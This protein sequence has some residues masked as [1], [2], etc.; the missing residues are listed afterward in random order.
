MSGGQA[1]NDSAIGSRIADI[2]EER[3]FRHLAQMP[4]PVAVFR[5]AELR[6]VFQNADA[7]AVLG[8]GSWLGKVPSEFSGDVEDLSA[9]AQLD[10][11]YASGE[12][13]VIRDMPFKV[14]G[15][16]P[17]AAQAFFDVTV[18][19]FRGLDD[20]IE[21]VMVVCSDVTERHRRERL[22]Q[23]AID[24]QAMLETMVRAMP[25]GVVI[26]DR[27][28]RI[29]HMNEANAKLNRC[30]PED[31]IGRSAAE[32]WPH[33][34]ADREAVLRRVLD[35]GEAIIDEEVVHGDPKSG[36]FFA[37]LISFYPIL[38]PD[39]RVVGVGVITLD[40]TERKRA[41]RERAELLVR[42][43]RARAEAEAERARMESLL[44]QAPFAAVL[45]EGPDHV[46]RL[47]NPSFRPFI[48][49]DNFLGRPWREV[50][51]EAVENGIMPMLDRVYRTGEPVFMNEF[52]FSHTVNGVRKQN[53]YTFALQP[54]RDADGIVRGVM[55][56]GL[57]VTEQVAARKAVEAANHEIRRREEF[58]RSVLDQLPQVV[59]TIDASQRVSFINGRWV[60]WTGIAGEVQGEGWARVLHPD[61][62]PTVRA[63]WME[64]MKTLA[65]WTVECRLRVHDGTFRWVQAR[66]LPMRDQSSGQVMWLGV[67]SDIDAQKRMD[68]QRAELF[69]R[70]RAAREEAENASRLKDQFLAIVS[71]ELRAPLAA[72]LLWEGLLRSPKSDE[73]LK[74]KA[75]DA[76][77]QSA[78]A[79]AKLIED[80]LD[81]SRAIS[82]KL[83][84]DQQPV[85][86]VPVIED[87]IASEL[88]A[89]NLKEIRIESNFDRSQGQVL[90]DA[91]RLKQIV[92]NLLSNA[93]KFT[94]AGGKVSV[95]AEA[96]EDFIEITVTDT[97]RGIAP[98][99]Q[100]QLF[101]P[102]SQADGSIT[103]A[104]GGLGL[105][106]SIV[107]RLVHLHGGT[108]SAA[109]RG[110][111]TGATFTVQ[112]PR[113][114][115]IT[116]V[117]RS[118]M[119]SPLEGTLPGVRILLVDDET[120]VREALA[121]ILQIA[122]AI[123]TRA[124]SAAEGLRLFEQHAFDLV[125]GDLSMPG[126]D[127][128]SFIRR[129]RS[130][131]GGIG[132][133]VVAV[134]LTAH[135]REEER[136][137]AIE[138]GYHHHLPK[139]IEPDVLVNTLVALLK[140]HGART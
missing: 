125:I 3:L 84:I 13:V 36:L 136:T 116:D 99:F 85:D 114:R 72:L 77:R 9:L 40:I 35:S 55:S 59:W 10:R 4:F 127:G 14:K 58:F 107:H 44:N 71:H 21:G 83:H 18:Q 118:P 92:V 128:F 39:D 38:T 73:A 115:P 2:S 64:S 78:R 140:D 31:V 50:K 34:F 95:K 138:A 124:S 101:K 52:P 74:T 111:G 94:P 90:G 67:A 108:V 70:E 28:L 117:V 120:D 123:P 131:P 29:T 81:V 88:Q 132:S 66:S 80:L 41:E 43:Q 6:C 129:L 103:R 61:D 57:N 87:A 54:V 122:G 109:S 104:H 24:R 82:G 137:R 65:P 89:A 5:G 119:R 130:L 17:G 27:A 75:L 8:G 56:T 16:A 11:V 47:A 1:F 135:A 19:P 126:E 97:G 23:E 63:S 112:L 76:I 133:K 91:L 102:F 26:L 48:G 121:I 134:A 68:E 42:E 25:A 53:F 100:P 7:Q 22:A 106:L 32:L 12:V 113:L 37:G 33:R 20:A 98:E 86:V 105:G 60:E 46:V 79:Q 110:A 96:V 69:E 93:I 139:P 62:H 49:H 15:A 51:P 30:R 45:Y